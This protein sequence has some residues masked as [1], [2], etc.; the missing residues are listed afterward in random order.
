MAE[1]MSSE[2]LLE[3]AKSVWSMLDDLSETDPEAYKRFIDQQVK[4]AKE[5]MEQLQPPQPSFCITTFKLPEVIPYKVYINVCS[6]DRVPA[7][8]SEKDPIPIMTGQLQEH[9]EKGKPY[10]TIDAIFNTTTLQQIEYKQDHRNLLVHLALDY[11]EAHKQ[12]SVSRNYKNLKIKYKGN[13]DDLKKYLY[14]RAKGGNEEP[15]GIG[16]NPGNISKDSLLSQLSSIAVSET[17]EDLGLSLL[18]NSS[19]Q[20]KRNLIQEI[21]SSAVRSQEI[22]PVYNV[23]VKNSS[24]GR[25]RRLVVTVELPGVLSVAD[26]DLEISEVPVKDEETSATFNKSKHKLT[27][28]IP[29]RVGDS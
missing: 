16:T 22:V 19:K 25:P 23:A 5:D 21:S 29:T 8:E 6:W 17:V 28:K 15:K 27:I 7:P 13:A 4:G 20:D 10:A 24:E 18:G 12:I 11:L 1:N 2:Q 3:Q 26:C 14:P 9:Q